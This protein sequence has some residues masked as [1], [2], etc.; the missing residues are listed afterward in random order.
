MNALLCLRGAL[1]SLSP[2]NIKQIK[3]YL[4]LLWADCFVYLNLEVY[5]PP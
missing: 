2:S 5:L 4:N 3:S 1:G